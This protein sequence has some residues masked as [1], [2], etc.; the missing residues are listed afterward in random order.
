MKHTKQILAL[1][2]A[3][4]MLLCLAACGR[5]NSDGSEDGKSGGR[6]KPNET[7]VPEFVYKASF[8]PI[9]TGSDQ[10]RDFYPRLTTEDAFYGFVNEKTGQRELYEGEVLQWEGQLDIYEN[11]LY[12]LGID[13]SFTNGVG[14]PLERT[15]TYLK[16]LL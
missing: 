10:M 13:G 9:D 15:E 11:S 4:A 7:P 16:D 12:R 8:A 1:L 2:L 6:K 14:L 5:T 3:A